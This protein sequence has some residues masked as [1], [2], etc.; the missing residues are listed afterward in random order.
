MYKYI[1]ETAGG[2]NW[3]A[4]FALITFVFIFSLAVLLIFTKSNEEI[5]RVAALPLDDNDLMTE[6]NQSN[7]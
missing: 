5:D 7:E 4:V 6:N 2:I 3:M 1:L